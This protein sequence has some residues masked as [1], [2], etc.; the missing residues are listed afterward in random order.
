MILAVLRRRS[1]P[2][3]GL[4]HNGPAAM[5]HTELHT[6]PRPDTTVQQGDVI[7]AMGTHEQLERLQKAVNP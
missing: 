7:I 1:A 6:N 4:A 5:P 2:Q 3:S